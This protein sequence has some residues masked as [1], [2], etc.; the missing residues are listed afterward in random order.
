MIDADTEIHGTEHSFNK[1]IPLSTKMKQIT[2]TCNNMDI[3]QQH[4][5]N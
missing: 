1:G 2:D 4:Y 5:P 3:S